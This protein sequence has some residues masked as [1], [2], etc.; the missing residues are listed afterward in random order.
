MTLVQP[1]RFSWWKEGTDPWYV[2]YDLY[3][4]TVALG[5]ALRHN[6]NKFWFLKE[7]L[8]LLK[9][10]FLLL[11]TSQK[12]A[13]K[14]YHH[15]VAY[16]SREEK[17]I[18]AKA[19]PWN[20]SIVKYSAGLW[21]DVRGHHKYALR[22]RDGGTHL[23]SQYCRGWGRRQRVQGKSGLHEGPVSPKHKTKMYVLV[24]WLFKIL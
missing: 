18:Q 13:S 14:V 8:C 22:V 19:Q 24:V 6:N 2:S 20:N 4:C 12:K 23:W 15:T 16:N 3:M 1:L 7:C 21:W 17:G 5:P 10:K 11:E 9:I